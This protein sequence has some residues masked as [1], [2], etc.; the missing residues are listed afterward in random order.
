MGSA[1]RLLFSLFCIQILATSVVARNIVSVRHDE[2]GKNL[3]FRKR[4]GFGCEGGGFGGVVGSGVGSGLGGGIGKS[5]EV[6]NGGFGKGR[7]ILKGGW[8]GG[9]GGGR[10]GGG[11]HGGFHGGVG[12]RV[13][14][15]AGGGFGKGA[16]Q[17]TV[18]LMALYCTF[19]IF[20]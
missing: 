6:R 2:E 20:L 14:S 13:H 18:L 5:G 3:A 12:V 15:G 8:G 10:S 4:G 7:R 11:K 16:I 19:T 9:R 17:Q 1:W